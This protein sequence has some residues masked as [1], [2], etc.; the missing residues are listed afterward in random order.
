[1]QLEAEQAAAAAAEDF[2]AA[3]ALDERLRQLAAQR[4]Q[5]A[6]S[7]QGIAASLAAAAQL[8]LA[9]RE[10]QLEAWSTAADYLARLQVRNR[11]R[12]PTPNGTR[13]VMGRNG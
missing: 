2:D 12:I 3:A 9:V 8:R 11:A 13:G 1:M 7:E 6:E 5:L 10:R 4:G